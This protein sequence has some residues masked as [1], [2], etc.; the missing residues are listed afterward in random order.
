MRKELARLMGLHCST[1]GN[2]KNDIYIKNT[3]GQ[4]VRW[5][6][7]IYPS[8]CAGVRD[9]LFK[10]YP[11]TIIRVSKDISGDY[12]VTLST[13]GAIGST[14]E[15]AF[16]RAVLQVCRKKITTVEELF[17]EFPNARVEVEQV[18]THSVVDI[19]INGRVFHSVRT[20]FDKALA[21]AL[22]KI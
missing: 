10:E 5:C 13:G 16:C 15:Q 19:F 22:E 6:P 17:Q 12:K 7:D 9:W 3:E 18:V 8:G 2:R 1:D 14:Y 4:S 11:N 21:S 20:T